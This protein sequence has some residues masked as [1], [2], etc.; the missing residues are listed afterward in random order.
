MH[1]NA[2]E[3]DNLI[4]KLNLCSKE[5]ARWKRETFGNVGMEIRRL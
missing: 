3:V 1:V 2:N 5:L 4:A